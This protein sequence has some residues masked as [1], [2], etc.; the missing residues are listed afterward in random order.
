MVFNELDAVNRMLRYVGELPLPTDID[1]DNLPEGHEALTAR[2]TLAETLREEQEEKWWFN[3]F[4]VDYVP[5]TSG[6][7]TLPDNV[8]AFESTD[9]TRY[10]REGG[11]LYNIDDDTKVFTNNVTLK[12]RL[13]IAFDDIPDTFKTYV[14]LKATQTF[15]IYLNGDETV[16]KDLQNKVSIQRIKLER[17]HL[18]QSKF[19]LIKGTRLIDRGTSPTALS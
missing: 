6:Y 10:T 5:Q 19:N 18:K 14:I 13:S 2:E 8:V 17:E 1:F 7:I 3:W 9:N 11:D 12:V 16:Q 4:E 15:H